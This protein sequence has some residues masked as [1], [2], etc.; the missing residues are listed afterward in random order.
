VISPKLVNQNFSPIGDFFFN[1]SLPEIVSLLG[2]YANQLSPNFDVK[3]GSYGTSTSDPKTAFRTFNLDLLTVH[4]F[5]IGLIG[6]ENGKDN[7]LAKM[8][9]ALFT[10]GD[11]SLVRRF[12]LN[13]HEV[14]KVLGMNGENSFQRTSFL[15]SMMQIFFPL[16]K[17]STAENLVFNQD[18]YQIDLLGQW[19][20][21][22]FDL[23]KKLNEV[24]DYHNF[25]NQLLQNNQTFSLK[26]RENE[27]TY[28]FTQPQQIQTLAFLV[29]F[30]N[31][32]TLK[33]TNYIF[34]LRRDDVNQGYYFY[35]ITS[36]K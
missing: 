10:D 12:G 31:P 19:M 20:K 13:A 9:V 3:T 15:G 23:I 30:T 1:S 34:Y 2:L 17:D 21:N 11:N 28:F 24:G 36:D 26:L 22:G 6:D 14:L 27:L 4:R 8:I 35:Q 33:K 7:L 25:I 18:T 29:R 32:L 16:L 5:L